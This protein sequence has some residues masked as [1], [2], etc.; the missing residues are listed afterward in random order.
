MYM[1]QIYEINGVIIIITCQLIMMI[2]EYYTHK[3]SHPTISHD[4]W[5]SQ[6]SHKTFIVF[7]CY[8]F[9]NYCILLLSLS[10]MYIYIYIYIYIIRVYYCILLLFYYHLLLLYVIIISQCCI[11][12]N[13]YISL[14][15][16]ILVC[17]YILLQY[18]IWS[19]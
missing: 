7:Y 3:K 9:S 17:H 8:I 6:L 16:I 5:L 11:L 15:R 2:F 1:H 14:Y 13:Y 10:I 19:L 4:C 18:L 12:S